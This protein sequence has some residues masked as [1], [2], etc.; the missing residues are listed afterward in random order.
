MLEI[1]KLLLEQTLD[2]IN[3]GN[4]NITEQEQ[5]QV[6]NLFQQINRKEL[7]KLEAAEYLGISRSTFDNYVSK[8]LL[9]KGQKRQGFKEKFWNKFELKKP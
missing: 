2:N 7:S 9:P 1:L 8:G 6:I 5:E 4:T 3:S